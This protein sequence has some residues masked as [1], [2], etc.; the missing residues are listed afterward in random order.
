MS[1]IAFSLFIFNLLPLPSADGSHVFRAVLDL[2]PSRTPSPRTT[3]VPTQKPF[4][5]TLSSVTTASS[6]VYTSS[7]RLNSPNVP[8]S[9]RLNTPTISMFRQFELHSD[10]DDSDDG[11]VDYESDEENTGGRGIGRR[12]K[13][14]VWRSK[15]R[16]GVE[17]GTMG[18]A[19]A[20]AAGWVM[21]AL[22]RSS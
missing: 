19:G 9:S 21:L 8:T 16:R 1:T 2:M 20:W 15:V 10:D 13:E 22:L 3:P 18:I 6:P 4:Q 12:S 14:G 11:D 7:S 5:A 17:M